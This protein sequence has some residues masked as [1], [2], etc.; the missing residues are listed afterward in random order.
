MFD[1]YSYLINIKALPDLVE[2]PIDIIRILI[3]Y[4]LFNNDG[5]NRR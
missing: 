2:A 5:T 4:Q 3:T 1:C